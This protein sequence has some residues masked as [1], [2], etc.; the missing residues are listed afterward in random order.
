MYIYIFYLTVFPIRNPF[1]LV[2]MLCTLA[3]LSRQV[4]FEPQFTWGVGNL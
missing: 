4:G 1:W 2:T 3:I